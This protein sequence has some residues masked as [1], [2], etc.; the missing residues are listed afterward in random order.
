MILL[1]HALAA[2]NFDVWI[3]VMKFYVCFGESL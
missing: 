2:E 3:E 1:C